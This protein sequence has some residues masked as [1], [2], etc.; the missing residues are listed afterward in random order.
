MP[1]IK[2]QPIQ[3]RE[4][5]LKTIEVEEGCHFPRV[6]RLI[7]RRV[8][9]SISGVIGGA[10][11]G[12]RMNI[13]AAT[14][15]YVRSKT[16]PRGV[17]GQLSKRKLTQKDETYSSYGKVDVKA[18]FFLEEEV[19]FESADT[20]RKVRTSPGHVIR[21]SPAKQRTN[22][23]RYSEHGAEQSKPRERCREDD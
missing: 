8:N 3:S 17:S 12:P 4:S 5:V 10:G 18:P 7:L 9:S 19:S 15:T 14:V 16:L 11:C 2:A 13:M 23:R 22:D 20:R 1:S 21:E 6:Q